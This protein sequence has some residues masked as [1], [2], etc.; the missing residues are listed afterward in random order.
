MEETPKMDSKPEIIKAGEGQESP[1]D[2]TSFHVLGEPDYSYVTKSSKSSLNQPQPS[3]IHITK[4]SRV[5]DSSINFFEFLAGVDDFASAVRPEITRKLIYL[6]LQTSRVY[7]G[8]ASKTL[9]IQN[10]QFERQA[11]KLMEIGILERVNIKP[12]SYDPFL[13]W[14]KNSTP[15]LPTK[16]IKLYKFTDNYRKLFSTLEEDLEA[17]LDKDT[18]D[19]IKHY[20][21]Q[22][23]RTH[24][25]IERE[26]KLMDVQ[27]RKLI[28][29]AKN[30]INSILAGNCFHCGNACIEKLP[31]RKNP[32]A[33]INYR[34]LSGNLVCNDCYKTL[35][36]EKKDGNL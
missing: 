36:L 9:K 7:C 30:G 28:E 32:H 27:Q 1:R 14:A 20:R 2:S 6:T 18:V 34:K 3:Y 13:R 23:R 11:A 33:D 10:L 4:L 22:I 29:N 8:L 21:F 15:N 35:Y 12:D 19:I 5:K 31:T 17:S 26:K 25:D 24:R 16:K